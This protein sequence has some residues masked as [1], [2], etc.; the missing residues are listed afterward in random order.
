M[1]AQQAATIESTQDVG[2]SGLTGTITFR[3]TDGQGNVVAGPST[4]NVVESPGDPG[5]YTW[6]TTAPGTIGQYTIEASTDGSYDVDTVSVESLTVHP[7]GAVATLPPIAPIEGIATYGFCQAWISADDVADACEAFTGGT[8]TEPLEQWAVVATEV[9]FEASGR[10]YTGECGPITVRPCADACGCWA[11]VANRGVDGWG[12]DPRAGQ[13]ACEGRSCGCS[14]VSEIMLAGRPR[15]VTEVLIDGLAIDPSEY[16][17]DNGGRLVR[18]RDPLEPNLRLT[19]PG[20][21]IIDLDDSE[22][23]TFAISYTYGLDPPQSGRLAAAALACQLW[24][25]A[26]N[27]GRCK[28]PNNTKVLVRGGV[29]IGIGT[30]IAQSLLKG[31]TGI[32]AIDAFIAAHGEDGDV[33][34]VWSPDL[35]PY[36]RR[37]G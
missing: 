8:D 35:P 21:Q 29:T 20:C 11:V 32:L 23:G 14:P 2:E 7:A 37:V 25:A 12:W 28:L 13:W 26:N 36:P 18:L 19:W 34:G 5:I 27:S 15:E 24:A 30:L 3:I 22:E 6:S 9:L 4:A 17:L 16:R 1:D 31:E 33:P 10:I